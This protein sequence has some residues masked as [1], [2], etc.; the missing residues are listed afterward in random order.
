[1]GIGTA[2]RLRTLAET[3]AA[4]PRQVLSLRISTTG[5]G[6]SGL[7]LETAPQIKRSSITSPITRIRFRLNRPTASMSRF[8]SQLYLASTIVRGNNIAKTQG[9]NGPE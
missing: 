1:M 2:P 4:P 6:A 5:T 7:I 3:L 8:L 9:I